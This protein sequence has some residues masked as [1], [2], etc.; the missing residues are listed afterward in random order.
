MSEVALP[1]SIERALGSAPNP[2]KGLH[3]PTG[4]IHPGAIAAALLFV[5][6]SICADVEATGA[7]KPSCRA[8]AVLF[9]A[10]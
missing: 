6:S 9:V 1:G 10:C 7:R 8:F 2:E 5:A 4:F 3:P